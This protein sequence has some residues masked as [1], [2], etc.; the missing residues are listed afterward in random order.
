MASPSYCPIAYSAMNSDLTAMDSS[1]FTLTATLNFAVSSSNVA[2][3]G[4]YSILVTGISGDVSATSTF[5][6]TLTN[7]CLT[8]V[9][10]P[11]SPTT[12]TYTLF[13]SA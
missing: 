4:S 5:S 6:V 13:N 3:A 12:T 9:L 8:A 7:P 2:K 1:V 11:S 10:I